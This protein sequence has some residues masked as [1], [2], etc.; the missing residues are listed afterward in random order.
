VEIWPAIDILRGQCVRLWQ[1]DYERVTVYDSCPVKMARYWVD[2]GADRLHLVDLDAAREGIV[3]NI[4]V[5]KQVIEEIKVP[6]QVGGGVRSEET[7]SQ[8]LDRG[9]GR[10]VVGTAA[11]R[12]P[13]WFRRMCR[14]FPQRI[15]LG[16]DA[17]D[18]QVAVEGWTHT[19]QTAAV[20]LACRF[21]SEPLGAIIFT[22]I[23]TDGTL[24][25]PN[26]PAAVQ[27]QESVRVPVIV[28]GGVRSAEDVRRIAEAGLAGCIIGRALY[29]G[30]LSLTEAIR[31]AGLGRFSDSEE[32]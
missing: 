17:R 26:I 27:L 21:A 10:V 29:E 15:A 5:I 2:Q 18:G 23:A 4:D 24:S 14:K 6:C 8:L 19:T 13:E 9:A 28:S 7:I 16:L 3:V 32:T 22:D 25:G 30:T 1:G 31:A 12:S 20:D 11:V